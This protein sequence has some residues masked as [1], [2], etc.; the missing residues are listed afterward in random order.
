MKIIAVSLFYKPIWPGF[1]T[2][3]AQHVIDEC[4]AIGNDVTL[5][6]GRIPKEMQD[7]E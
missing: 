7:N 4:T 6:T 5:F 3:F 2:R 1:G